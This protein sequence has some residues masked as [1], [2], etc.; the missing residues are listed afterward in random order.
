M[1]LHW[2]VFAWLA[3]ALRCSTF[4][5]FVFFRCPVWQLARADWLAPSP[6]STFHLLPTMAVSHWWLLAGFW[7]DCTKAVCSSWFEAYND[8]PFAMPSPQR[9]TLFSEVPFYSPKILPQGT[10]ESE[11]RAHMIWP[12]GVLAKTICQFVN[13]WHLYTL[14]CSEKLGENWMEDWIPRAPSTSQG[15]QRFRGAFHLVPLEMQYQN[16]AGGNDTGYWQ[17]SRS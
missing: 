17:I 9:S 14:Q 1:I 3:L 6:I 2:I 11:L 8:K 12:G 4:L 5:F 16:P 7:G 10:L 13:C 15:G